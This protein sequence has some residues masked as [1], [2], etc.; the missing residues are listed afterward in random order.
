MTGWRELEKGPD[1][2]QIR[3]CRFKSIHP[4]P[5]RC[6]TAPVCRFSPQA[7]SS[8]LTLEFRE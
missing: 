5:P 8:G 4:V 2:T 1:E 3:V 6:F 7:D